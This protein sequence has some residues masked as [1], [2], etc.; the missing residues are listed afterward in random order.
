MVQVSLAEGLVRA[1]GTAQGLLNKVETAD[2]LV[3]DKGTPKD[4]WS[5]YDL[6]KD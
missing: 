5:E 6:P 2:V 1:E 4:L 3:F